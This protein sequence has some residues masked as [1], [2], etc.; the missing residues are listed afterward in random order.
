MWIITIRR[1]LF[2]SNGR[3]IKKAIEGF[4][5]KKERELIFKEVTKEG[6]KVTT[7]GTP[8]FKNGKVYIV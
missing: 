5:T 6:P 1:R 4:Y 7:T 8:V 3:N 2:M